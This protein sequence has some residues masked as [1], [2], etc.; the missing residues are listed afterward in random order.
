MAGAHWH[1]TD[2]SGF[3]LVAALAA[4]ALWLSRSD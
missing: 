1:A 4:F 3:V 2:T